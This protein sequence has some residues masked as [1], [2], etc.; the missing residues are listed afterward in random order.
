MLIIICLCVSSRPLRLN[1]KIKLD[2]CV[3]I[4]YIVLVITN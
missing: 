3:K 2:N 1:K 4:N